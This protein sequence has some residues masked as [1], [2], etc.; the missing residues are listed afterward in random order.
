[1]IP[2]LDALL[3]LNRQGSLPM[4]EIVMHVVKCVSQGGGKADFDSLPQSLKDA[5]ISRVRDYRD[6]GGWVLLSSSGSEDYA[7]YAEAFINKI[8]GL[9]D[10][11]GRSSLPR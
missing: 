11:P 8:G 1:M 4:W 10:E 6:S 7:P 3:E 5:V 2:K 9:P